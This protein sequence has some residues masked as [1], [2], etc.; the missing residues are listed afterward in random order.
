MKRRLLSIALTAA[1]TLSLVTALSP[2]ALASGNST[3]A[4]VRIQPVNVGDTTITVSI[5]KGNGRF[6]ASSFTDTGLNY[7]SIGIVYPAHNGTVNPCR[8]IVVSGDGKSVTFEF[9][10]ANPNGPG[11]ISA[12]QQP[13]VV[14][15]TLR[16]SFR[17]AFLINFDTNLAENTQGTIHASVVISENAVV[18]EPPAPKLAPYYDLKSPDK[19]FLTEKVKTDTPIM[20]TGGYE[21]ASS[22]TGPW[23][24]VPE[25]G[26]DIK[27]SSAPKAPV[28]VRAMEF[29][30]IP[31]SKAVKVTPANYGKPTKYKIDYKNEIIKMKK[32]DQYS[33]DDG[34][35]WAD[36]RLDDKGKPIPYNAELF[37]SGGDGDMLLRKSATGKKPATETQTITSLPRAVIA[38]AE[39]SVANGKIT[40]DMKNYEIWIVNTAN[41]A[42]SK[43]GKLPK[44]TTDGVHEFLIRVKAAPKG[45]SAKAASLS[46]TLKV[47]YGSLSDNKSGI[48][49]AQI[50][51]GAVLYPPELEGLLIPKPVVGQPRAK[52][53]AVSGVYNPGL[54]G[55][56]WYIIEPQT[57][58]YEGLDD[59]TYPQDKIRFQVSLSATG[60]YKFENV[61]DTVFNLFP[62]CIVAE[63]KFSV[64][65][66]EGVT[67][68][69]LTIIY[70]LS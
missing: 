57:P 59:G 20:L 55:G 18:K 48:T 41:P 17:L 38:D 52:L 42:K 23:T 64:G 66:T 50:G 61:D 46:S 9:V 70:D 5:V 49:A 27:A 45:A 13:F 36:V 34:K 19:W 11:D 56:T 16:L 24:S 62:G 10:I 8:N 7:T 63:S 22:A 33:T 12:V 53:K 3:S 35:T 14:A 26:F 32:G 21:Y 58:L 2:A 43:W 1:I 44:I 54:E 29:G 4:D 40:S 28:F 39:L 60:E 69:H 30:K 6:N 47:T 51:S 15:Q 37:I 67:R 31:A 25:T 65:E 68:L